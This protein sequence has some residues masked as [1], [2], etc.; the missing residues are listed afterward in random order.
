MSP[1]LLMLTSRIALA[2]DCAPT[3]AS[4]L[5][6]LV[7][8][9]LDAFEA[10]DKD[11]YLERIGAAGAALPCL[12]EP[13]S[14]GLAADVHRGMGLQAFLVRD[15]QAAE[16]SFAAARALQPSYSFPSTLVP[17]HHPVLEMYLA[18]D[19]DSGS[20]IVMVPP[21]RGQILLDGHH[22]DERSSAFPQIAQ[23]LD[24]RGAV[25]WTAYVQHDQALPEYPVGSYD[26]GLPGIVEEALDPER[27]VWLYVEG[28]VGI[29]KGGLDRISDERVRVDEDGAPLGRSSVDGLSERQSARGGVAVGMRFGQILDVSVKGNAYVASQQWTTGWTLSDGSYD[30]RT[31]EPRPAWVV[32]VEPRMRLTFNATDLAGFYWLTGAG[33]TYF[34]AM[35]DIE[36]APYGFSP[37][38]SR[39]VF[40]V[41]FGAGAMWHLTERTSLFVEIP[42]TLYLL[43]HQLQASEDSSVYPGPSTVSSTANWVYSGTLGIQRRF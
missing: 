3:T 5:Q 30:L 25:V 42:W 37:R 28:D 39:T 9:A 6:H 8:E 35:D 17:P 31:M 26:A 40:G 2:Q 14:A 4:T 34:P 27:K 43:G 12:T 1:S 38:P 23:Y 19:P 29:A 21:S 10:R 15:Q 13:L 36:R 41:T 24:E 11:A 16:L 20:Q 18:L 7:D 32:Q 33:V 22:S